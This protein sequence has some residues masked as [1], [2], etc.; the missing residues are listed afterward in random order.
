MFYSD[1]A[2]CLYKEKLFGSAP[3]LDQASPPRHPHPQASHANTLVVRV[4]HGSNGCNSRVLTAGNLHFPLAFLEILLAD[5]LVSL[6][7]A[8]PDGTAQCVAIGAGPDVAHDLAVAPHNLRV[9]QHRLRVL[10][11]DLGRG[12]THP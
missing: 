10:H 4:V 3:T 12:L 11:Q 1:A 6:H 9:I 5:G 2:A 8:Q 7:H